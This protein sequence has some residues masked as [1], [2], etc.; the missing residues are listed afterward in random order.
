M[1]EIADAIVMAVSGACEWL[2]VLWLGCAAI[3]VILQ[4]I[5][6]FRGIQE[7]MD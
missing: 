6:I 2:L 4:I 5:D 1:I 3:F 7:E